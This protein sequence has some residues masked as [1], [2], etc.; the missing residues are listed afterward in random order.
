MKKFL[1]LLAICVASITLGKTN[2]DNQKNIIDDI[3]EIIVLGFDDH[4]LPEVINIGFDDHDLPEVI[5]IGFD[6]HDL[7]EVINI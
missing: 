3:K 1:I 6:D 2:L 5:N 4:D 7:P